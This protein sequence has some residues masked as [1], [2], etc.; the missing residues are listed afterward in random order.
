M[1]HGGQVGGLSAMPQSCIREKIRRCLLPGLVWGRECL[2]EAVE[3]QAPCA[4]T[5][6][7]KTSRRGAKAQSFKEIHKFFIFLCVLAS[8]RETLPHGYA[9]YQLTIFPRHLKHIEPTVRGLS[10]KGSLFSFL[11]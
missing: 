10:E 2:F 11:Y 8:L 7:E 9:E 6:L 4:L 5:Y 1:P 3:W